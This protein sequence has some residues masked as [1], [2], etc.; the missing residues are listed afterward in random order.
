MPHA[1]EDLLDHRQHEHKGL[2]QPADRLDGQLQLGDQHRTDDLPEA[3][4]GL[5]CTVQLRGGGLERRQ[6]LLEPRPGLAHRSGHGVPHRRQ[7]RECRLQ[8]GQH[9]RG[10]IDDALPHTGGEG[11]DRPPVLPH[12]QRHRSDGRADRQYRQADAA[13]QRQQQA[14]T[15]GEHGQHAATKRQHLTNERAEPANARQQR[16]G[17]VDLRERHC[18]DAAGHQQPAQDRDQRSGADRHLC[19]RTDQGWVG[20]DPRCDLADHGG[21]ALGQFLELRQQGLAD[22][23]GHH[24]GG[25]LQQLQ[26]VGG[27]GHTRCVLGRHRAAIALRIGDLGEVALQ[28]LQIG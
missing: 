22:R 4:T 1:A 15:V 20:A 13:E 12:Q 3:A 2:H 17:A 28:Q 10:H 26:R 23:L 9:R 11:L 7:W 25:V 14:R 18:G 5:S 6:Q 16:N 24:H 27:G 21:G 8:L 19:D